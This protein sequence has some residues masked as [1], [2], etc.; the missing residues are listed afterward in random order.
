L[1]L[2]GGSTPND[3]NKPHGVAYASAATH[4]GE[5]FKL[6]GT[7]MAMNVMKVKVSS[8][9]TTDDRVNPIPALTMLLETALVMDPN[10]HIK[11]NDPSCSPIDKVTNI[12]K[13]KNIDKYA[14]DLQTNTIKKQFVYFVTLKT[15]ISFQNLKLSKEMYAWLKDNK[16]YI[17]QHAMQMNHTTPIGYL[18]SMHLTLSSGDAMKLLL[19]GYIPPDIEYNLITMSTFYITQKGKKVNTHIVEVHVNQKKQSAPRKS[20]QTAG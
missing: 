18:L 8:P 4:E 19:D 5:S 17:R 12:A 6:S 9:F 13:M 2:G 10:S 3:G 11:S 7:E 16:I 20:S 1:S 15:T 14:I